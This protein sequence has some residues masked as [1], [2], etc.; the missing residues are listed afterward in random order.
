MSLK[1][2]QQYKVSGT[3]W[4]GQVPYNWQITKL[5]SM[6]NERKEKVSDKD[7][8]PLS[9]T[10]NGI[11]PQLETAAKTNDGDN[12]K[13]VCEGDFVINSRSDRKG[14]S[15]L[16]ALTGSVSVISTVLKPKGYFN[17]YSH[18]L[19]KCQ[20]FQEEFYRVGHGIVA[21]LWST[22]FSEMRSILTPVPDF[23]EQ[24][25]I[26]RYLDWKTSQIA[27][28]IKAKKRMIELLKEQ[29]QVII[30]DAV[31]GKIDVRTGKPYP[32]Y[33]GSSVE[34][35]E[36]IPEEWMLFSLK[37]LAKFSPSKVETN[38]NPE[39]SEPVVFLPM[40]KV[41]SNG[42]VDCSL[43]LPYKELS[44]GFSYFK[45]GDV[46]IAKI[47]PCFENGKGAYLEYLESE[48]GFGTTEFITIRPGRFIDGK[49]LRLIL[50]S[51]W[52]L[53]IGE[54]YMTGSAGQKR[55][56][57]EFIKNFEIG[58]PTISEQY[59]IITKLNETLDAIDGA[60][61]KIQNELILI[62]EYRIRL[63]ADTV[64]GK[65]D[66]RNII[67][68]EFEEATMITDLEEPSDIEEFLDDTT[69]DNDL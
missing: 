8:P 58:L 19:L 64:T 22:K 31:T 16:S 54:K 1:P 32:N 52:F 56:S 9:V 40:E 49:Y 37:H 12:R 23:K 26:V 20:P 33:K 29:K 53:K 24:E 47:T 4:L 2:Y 69:V 68:S 5:G 43:K 27:K 30:N 42:V 39:S 36:K 3:H 65:V 63:I 50:S 55:I 67:V 48:F 21:D 11:L 35:L 28:F 62:Q 44:S 59:L 17:K 34:W 10:K 38:F 13:K 46:V 45:R 61:N 25:Q 51:N 66:V 41:T 60:I 18:Y 14:S 6:F 57:T 7:Y 15:G